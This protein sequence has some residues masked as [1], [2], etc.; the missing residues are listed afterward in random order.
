MAPTPMPKS[1][2]RTI[3]QGWVALRV[4]GFAP[5]ARRAHA[6]YFSALRRFQIAR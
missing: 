2:R 6:C 5:C 3:E 4:F 1:G